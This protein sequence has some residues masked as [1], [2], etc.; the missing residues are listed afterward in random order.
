MAAVAAALNAEV[1]ASRTNVGPL[2][3]VLT[4]NGLRPAQSLKERLA[5]AVQKGR[6]IVTDILPA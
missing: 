2:T 1:Q 3:H 4:S 6:D 5:R